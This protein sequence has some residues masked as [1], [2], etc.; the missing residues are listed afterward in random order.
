M[1]DASRLA[2]EHY[3]NFPVGSFL[4]PARLRPH[5]HRIYAFARTADDLAD[6]TRDLQGLL[7][8]RRALEDAL[9]CRGRPCELLRDVAS[10]IHEF[11]LPERLFFD[12][13]DAFELDLTKNR[14]ADEEELL[15]YCRLSANPVGRI[16]LHLDGEVDAETLALS[17][18]IC[19]G[20]QILNHAQDVRGD[21][22][23]RDRIYLPQDQMARH[24]VSEEDLGAART[25]EGLRACL[26]TWGEF[27]RRSFASGWPLTRRLEGRFGLEIR[28]ILQ[29][30]ALVL[31][32]MQAS[33]YRV[34]ERRPRIYK[35]DAPELLL[36]SLL[37]SWPPRSIATRPSPRNLDGSP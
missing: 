8:W 17:D 19:T 37:Q 10:T 27:V 15:D 11:A 1:N 2:A 26:A 9:Q 28:A 12:L 29:G 36:R 30:A 25:T 18:H 24:A 5:V 7:A 33:G 23:D 13:L 14:Y 34:L 6:E 3:E 21:Y 35:R 22:L 16:L 20:L 4:M 32:R 31:D